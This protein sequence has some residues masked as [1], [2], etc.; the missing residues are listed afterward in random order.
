MVLICT[1]A[2]TTNHPFPKQTKNIS[3]LIHFYA[4]VN[5][6]F[7]FNYVFISIHLH[8]INTHLYNISSISL[9]L[10]FVVNE[11]SISRQYLGTLAR[12]FCSPSM[13]VVMMIIM[14]LMMIDFG[15]QAAKAP[16]S[17]SIMERSLFSERYCFVQVISL[18][19]PPGALY[20]IMHQHYPA[21]KFLRFSLSP[22]PVSQ[23]SLQITTPLHDQC[24]SEQLRAHSGHLATQSTHREY[25]E[26]AHFTGR[27]H[28]T[29]G[30]N[31]KP[32]LNLFLSDDGRG[33]L[34]DSRRVYDFE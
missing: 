14:M 6:F 31:G 17:I 2:R 28:L 8:E 16:A 34:L 7:F 29:N 32:D 25:Q 1:Y 23:Y 21:G 12:N 19:A 27:A 18:L 4:I 20:A 24:K 30:Q 22:K 3:I 26:N 5:F 10:P 13:L 11:S 9:Y 15:D 33:R